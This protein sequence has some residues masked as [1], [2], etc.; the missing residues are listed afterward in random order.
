MYTIKARWAGL[1]LREHSIESEAE[2]IEEFLSDLKNEFESGLIYNAYGTEMKINVL[3][4]D[5]LHKGE[6]IRQ[7]DFKT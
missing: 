7:V 3:C 4:V 5:V 2:E 1:V 6:T